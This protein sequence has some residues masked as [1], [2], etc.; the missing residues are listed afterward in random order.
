MRD[1]TGWR[2]KIGLI[3]MASSTVMEP[4]FN[5]MAPEGVS[6]HTTRIPL[7][8]ASAEGIKS[9]MAEGPLE[10]AASLLAEA[11]LDAVSY[12]HLTLPTNR[13]V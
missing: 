3:Y 1:Y 13:E 10:Q 5:A 12:T 7:P 8:K 11:P 4:E 9:M 6:I 2:A